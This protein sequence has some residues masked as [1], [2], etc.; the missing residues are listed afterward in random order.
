MIGQVWR[1]VESARLHLYGLPKLFKF[2]LWDL[3]HVVYYPETLLV[4]HDFNVRILFSMV[5]SVHCTSSN[6]LSVE[7]G[8][9]V[10][11]C[12]AG[13]VSVSRISS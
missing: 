9:C 3:S 6:E 10:A 12:P 5:Y 4:C 8:L 7:T 2:Q 11:T 1:V 13:T